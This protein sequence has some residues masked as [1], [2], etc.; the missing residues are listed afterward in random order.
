M[1]LRNYNSEIIKEEIF[2]QICKEDLQG[3]T[4]D[5]QIFDLVYKYFAKDSEQLLNYIT[6]KKNQQEIFIKIKIAIPA[7]LKVT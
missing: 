3:D 1:Q 6:K 2:I 7:G 4:K 5:S